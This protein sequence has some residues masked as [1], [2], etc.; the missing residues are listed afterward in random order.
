MSV[1][2]KA[3]VEQIFSQ[4]FKLNYNQPKT[5][6]T[7]S[8]ARRNPLQNDL[9]TQHSNVNNKYNNENQLFMVHINSFTDVRST[10]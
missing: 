6:H 10:Q 4:F 7:A 8:K 2:Y 3:H 9:E 1:W 5:R